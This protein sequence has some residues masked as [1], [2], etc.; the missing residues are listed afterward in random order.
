M[1]L[2][3]IP[4]VL[5][6]VDSCLD[7]IIHEDLKVLKKIKEYV[8][9]NGGKRIRPLL[10]YYFVQL[11]G[12]SS[13]QWLDV[14]SVSELIHCASLLHD[15]V[16]DEA[17]VRRGLPTVGSKF[18][19]KTA[20][21]AG[22]YL[23]AC[24]IERLNRL[25]SPDLMDLYCKVLRDLSVSEL[26]QMEWERN[27][28]ITFQIYDSI[29]FGKTASLFGACTMSAG[30]LANL[31]KDDCQGLY[32]FGVLLGKLFQKKDDYLDYFLTK[33]QSGKEPMKDFH[34]GLFTYPVLVLL[35]KAGKTKEKA[36][37]ALLK[38]P[39]KTKKED[40]AIQSLLAE[41]KVKEAI[42]LELSQDKNQL[43]DF[44]QIFPESNAKK[45]IVEQINRFA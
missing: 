26:L 10:H 44:L 21:L 29:I 41:F 38:E 22:D 35:A 28:K 13:K 9:S 27:P 42:D 12:A 18:G 6:S 30:I 31:P 23:L 40:L 14:A 3:E 7:S 34:N 5:T 33:K 36:I 39:Q 2:L 45:I 11:L 25:E 19:N 43:L 1:K 17:P 24:G 8:V 37:H 32:D 4:K 15:D 20:I 16:I